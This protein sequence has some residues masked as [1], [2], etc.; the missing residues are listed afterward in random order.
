MSVV[1]NPIPAA[2]SASNNGEICEGEDAILTGGTVSGASY[3]WYSDSTLMSLISTDRV[4]T[5]YGLDTTTTY[6]LTVTVD[7]CTSEAT[8]TTVEVIPTPAAPDVPADF[9]VCEGDAITFTTSTL[10][11]DYYW[12]GPGGF[13]SMVRNPSVTTDADATHGGMYTLYVVIDGCVSDTA[14]FIVTVNPAPAKPVLSSNSE[15]CDGE[16]LVV[17][18]TS[19][20]DSFVYIRP[21]GFEIGTTDTILTF[22]STDLSY[23][24]GDWR[25]VAYSVEGCA[26]DTSDAEAVVIKPI[27]AA[28]SATND[29]PICEGEDVHLFAGTVV[30]GTYN[31]YSDSILTTLESTDQNPTVF[32]LDSTTT[33]WVTVTVDGCTSEAASTTVVVI[34]TPAT[35][36]PTNNGPVC[37]G[38]TLFLFAGV[39]ADSYE[40]TGPGGFTSTSRNPGAITPVTLAHAGDYYLTITIDGCT[41]D[42]GVTTV[43]VLP[44]PTAPVIFSNSPVCEGDSIILS[45]NGGFATYQWTLPSMATV[46][47]TDSFLIISPATG[48]DAGM[49]SVTVTNAAGCT[50]DPSTPIEV[51]VYEVP[52]DAAYAGEDFTV[53]PDA[54]GVTLAANP[55]VGGGVWTTPTDA[56]I[57]NPTLASTIVTNLEAGRSYIFIWTIGNGPCANT[58][59]DTVVVTIAQDPIANRDSFRLNDREILNDEWILGDDSLWGY[60]PSDQVE[61]T[62]IEGTYNGSLTF[63]FDNSFDYD[64]DEGFFGLDSF[65]YE[66]CLEECPDLCDTA[67]VYITVDPFKYFPDIITPND[68]GAN[69][70]FEI[71]GLENCPN[72]RL[73]IFNRWGD[74][75]YDKENYDN[76]WDGTYEGKPLP[77]GTYFYIFQNTDN[78]EI[79]HKGYITLYR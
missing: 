9:A 30:G 54:V 55:V 53:C 50:S 64:P 40:W 43:T 78:G 39:T 56:V 7:G 68:D 65:M 14:N 4:H 38:D 23:M 27:P 74:E 72:N 24:S 61:I 25:V 29:G 47:T 70:F 69:D 46:I 49:Y 31:W 32:G 44:K 35:P 6:W 48:T 59:T 63:N 73:T 20:A 26:S 58:S 33:Y 15:I 52:L 22:T 17:S 71:L 75:V 76:T 21:D 18:T 42:A 13:S 66:I 8:A 16:D 62:V 5:I 12:S 77:D 45:T 79:V 11:D 67:W 2:P 34:P 60:D 37:E 1:I 51:E 57:V 10:A 41:S 36:T 28:P 19:V 3:S